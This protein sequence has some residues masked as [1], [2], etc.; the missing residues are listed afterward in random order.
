VTLLITTPWPLRSAGGGQRLAHDIAHALT[1]R[2][3]DVVVAAGSGLTDRTYDVVG[4]SGFREVRLRLAD[5]AA[6][7]WRRRST[8]SLYLDGLESLAEQVR[9]QA[10]LFTP[11]YSSCARQA[12]AVAERRGIPFILWPAIHLDH[13]DHTSADARRFYGSADRLLCLSRVER[14]WLL[15]RVGISPERVLI[16]GYPWT[17]PVRAAIAPLRPVAPTRLLG[18][19]AFVGHKRFED[20]IETVDILRRRHRLD[21]RLTL[22][23]AGVEPTVVAGL[24][25]LRT[26]L[27]LDS[28][29][30]FVVEASDTHLASLY[31]NADVF[32]FTSRS[33]SFGVAVLEAI[34]RATLPIVYPHPVYRELVEGSGFGRV[35]AASTPDA[36]A[37]AIASSVGV[38]A[39]DAGNQRDAW[40]ARQSP[41]N[42]GARLTAMLG[43]LETERPVARA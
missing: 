36:L 13:E 6:G 5:G 37:A 19:G 31:Q 35:A 12:R 16:P 40:L 41:A 11:H 21:A 2:G 28:Y 4:G 24:R 10:L 9:P 29:V 8:V 17:G 38:H 22:A 39:A 27:E 3:I 33:E 1:A 20:Q 42:V 43:Q 7:R 25:R 26:R 32:L 30:E 18:V 15:E 14:Q 23:G 34:A